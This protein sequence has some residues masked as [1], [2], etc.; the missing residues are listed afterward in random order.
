MSSLPR[1]PITIVGGGLSGLALAIVLQRRGILVEL[2][3]SHTYPH[4]RVCGEFISGLRPGLLDDLGIADLFHDA[5]HHQTTRWFSPDGTS[6]HHLKIPR[7][8]LGISRYTLD[9]RLLERFTQLGGTFIPN[10]WKDH[11]RLEKVVYATGRRHTKTKTNTPPQ[12]I[13]LKMH[14]RNFDSGSDLEMHLGDGGYVGASAV[15]NGATNLCGL[16]P[17]AAFKQGTAKNFESALDAVGLQPLRERIRSCEVVSGSRCGT[18]HFHQGQQPLI[19]N[20]CT[21]GDAL[22]QIPPFTG[23][24]MAMALESA[25]LT[26]DPITHYLAEELTWPQTVSEVRKVILKQHSSRVRMACLLHPFISHG[27]LSRCWRPFGF[28]LN[29][30]PERVTPL[31]WGEALRAKPL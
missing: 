15:E 29:H 23:H 18:T 13:G 10:R 19:K 8:A 1:Q 24:G 25:W 31:L 30:L 27:I 12:W 9:T 26:A 4:H 28:L 6:F 5:H 11:D 20:K 2:F 17:I 14:I 7:P 21:L 16:F 3:E 22:Q